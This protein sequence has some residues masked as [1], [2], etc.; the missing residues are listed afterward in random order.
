MYVLKRAMSILS[1]FVLRERPQC[2]LIVN[3]IS[4]LILAW[5]PVLFAQSAPPSSPYAS[6]KSDEASPYE[7]S[8]HSKDE[9][10][11]KEIAKEAEKKRD[12]KEQA[13][14]DAASQQQ[15]DLNHAGDPNKHDQL[16]Q[17]ELQRRLEVCR[18]AYANVN[19]C[20]AQATACST[21]CP[22]RFPATPNNYDASGFK[23]CLDNCTAAQQ[24]CGAQVMSECNGYQSGAVPLP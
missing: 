15:E 18:L 20:A 4:T 6:P 9:A 16:V 8:T 7:G 24:M 23:A 3:S 21:D 14:A 22:R 5:G 17:R 10:R 11:V 1:P 12:T 13:L 19:A 2:S